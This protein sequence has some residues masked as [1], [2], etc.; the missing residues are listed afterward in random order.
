MMEYLQKPPKKPPKMVAKGNFNILSFS[1]LRDI[2]L[3][4]KLFNG[5]INNS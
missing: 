4:D 5:A 3:A 1:V 2:Y